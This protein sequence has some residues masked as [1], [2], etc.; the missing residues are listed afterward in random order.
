MTRRATILIACSAMG[1]AV[2]G[3]IVLLTAR[4]L[5]L[6]TETLLPV[7]ALTAKE[8]PYEI[9]RSRIQIGDKRD[10]AV[11]ALSDAWFHATCHYPSGSVDDLFFYGP[12]DQ[13]QVKV[14]LVESKLVDRKTLVHFIGS[15][16]NYMLHLY[17]HCTPLPLQVFGENKPTATI[18][19]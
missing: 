6:G 15:V 14:V 4:D 2:M 9:A 10:E 17:D 7:E 3:C 13:N 5:F 1:C 16:E 8:E 12:Q 18:A 11:G 19:P